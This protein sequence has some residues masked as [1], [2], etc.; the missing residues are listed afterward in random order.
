MIEIPCLPAG[1]LPIHSTGDDPKGHK[2]G[3]IQ[4][5]RQSG[6]GAVGDFFSLFN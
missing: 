2:E 4:M 1:R 5:S 6:S 3:E